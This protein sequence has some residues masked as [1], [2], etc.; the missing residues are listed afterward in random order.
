M[1]YGCRELPF[2]WGGGGRLRFVNNVLYFDRRTIG[3]LGA[4]LMGAGIIQVSIDKG[5][6]VIM[7]DAR[8]EGLVRGVTQIETGLINAVKRKKLTELV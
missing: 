1:S 3:V 2:P 6:N 7:K 4:G 8:E 5:Y